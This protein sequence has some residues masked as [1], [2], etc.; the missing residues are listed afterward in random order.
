MQA[1]TLPIDTGCGS[2]QTA[3]K[4][5]TFDSVTVDDTS[6]LITENEACF[7]KFH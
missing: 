4:E 2:F 3:M 1:Q 5:N 7:F 6:V